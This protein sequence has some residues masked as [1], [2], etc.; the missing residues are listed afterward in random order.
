MC[1]TQEVVTVETGTGIHVQDLTPRIRDH[2]ARNPVTAGFVIVSSRHTATALVIN[3]AEDRLLQDLRVFLE[4]LV[5]KDA[6][7]LHNDIH[8]RECPPDEP[9]NAHSHLAAMLLGST[10]VIPVVE[11]RL[12]LGTWQSVLLIDLDG[13]RRRTVTIQ[14]RGQ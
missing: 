8:L 2:L 14:L 6:P 4:R 11:G 5:P 9:P 3:E 1:I 10:E 12:P 7:Y 13:P